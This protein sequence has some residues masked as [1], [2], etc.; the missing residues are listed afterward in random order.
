MVP[1]TQYSCSVCE[2]YSLLVLVIAAYQSIY[3]PQR[4]LIILSQMEYFF[5][6]VADHHF[7]SG[8]RVL[9]DL[10]TGVVALAERV[11]VIASVKKLQLVDIYS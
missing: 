8:S 5:T 3:Q 6:V 7:I 1:F 4:L 10:V 9:N 2:T 11:A